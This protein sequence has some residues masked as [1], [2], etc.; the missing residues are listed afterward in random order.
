LDPRSAGQ[1]HQHVGA[2]V[3]PL[4]RALF[5]STTCAYTIHEAAET[6]GMWNP[7][8]IASLCEI[9]DWAAAK[10]VV[11]EATL[12]RWQADFLHQFILVGAYRRLRVR[13][14]AEAG[15]VL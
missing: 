7:D 2:A 12:R 6:T 10:G 4:R 14:R 15:Q 13:R 1:R 3:R 9:F 8:V 5:P 11:P